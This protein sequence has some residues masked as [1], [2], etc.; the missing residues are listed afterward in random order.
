MNP[1]SSKWTS[2]FFSF[3]VVLNFLRLRRQGQLWEACMPKDPDRLALLTQEAD[4]YRIPILRDQAIVLLQS[5]TEK[6]DQIYVNEARTCL[7]CT[8]YYSFQNSF[9]ECRQKNLTYD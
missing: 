6:A 1:P 7:Q 4:F 8:V 9:N 2:L 5:C 3:G